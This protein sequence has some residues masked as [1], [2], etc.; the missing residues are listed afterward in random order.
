MQ[1]FTMAPSDVPPIDRMPNLSARLG[2]ARADR[3]RY[4]QRADTSRQKGSRNIPNTLIERMQAYSYTDEFCPVEDIISGVARLDHAPGTR[5]S[6]PLSVARL[7]NILQCV[8]MINTREIMSML[9]VEKRQ[10]QVYV[11][12]IKLI[13]FHLEKHFATEKNE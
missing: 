11:K 2:K 8:E 6:K 7:Y 3:I 12:A 5:A 9:D 10:A 4:L 13:M 1:R